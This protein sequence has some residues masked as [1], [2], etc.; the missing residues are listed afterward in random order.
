MKIT[1]LLEKKM[2][3]SVY[4]D[5]FKRLENIAKI[6]YEIEVFVPEGNF[7]HPKDSESSANTVDVNDL[8]SFS[9]LKS[10]FKIH[11]KLDR[12][13]ND[14][15][16]WKSDEEDKWVEDSWQD[17]V[18]DEDDRNAESKARAAALRKAPSFSLDAWIKSMGAKELIDTYNLEPI[19]GYIDDNT[20]YM[21]DPQS[22]KWHDGFTSTSNDLA[23][24]L[25]AVLKQEVKV[26]AT[27]YSHWN[28]VSDSSI[29]DKHGNSDDSGEQEGFGV[30]IVSPP[31]KPSKALEELKLVLGVLEKYDIETNESTGIHVNISLNGIETIDPLKLVLFMGESYVLKLFNRE[32]NTYTRSQYSAILNSINH[33]GV[34]PSS[35]TELMKQAK[36]AVRNTGKYFSVNLL[37]LPHYLEFRAAGGQDY[38]KRYDEIK[39]LTGRWLSSVEI[40]SNP[41][42]YKNEYMKKVAKLLTVSI[43]GDDVVINPKMSFEDLVISANGKFALDN[44][45]DALSKEKV[46]R[47]RAMMLVFLALDKIKLPALAVKQL[48][49]AKKMMN[50][51]GVT[52]KDILDEV[53]GTINEKAVKK[54]MTA[55]KLMQ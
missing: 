1:D 26:G 38:H 10:V 55:L 33:D 40:A 7:F 22:N 13:N 52:A 37:H 12:L 43:S 51:A 29:L 47:V 14:Y 21:E 24:H 17:F 3:P 50:H 18:G 48:H 44:F 36:Q 8:E 23:V 54:V 31:L 6:G 20:V 4:A 15:A 2:S 27:G 19:Y 5:T 39:D 11:D 16:S 30:E 53:E 25:G 41:E 45:N 42:M 49:G 34:L 28:L 9:D 32:D 35:A 46:M